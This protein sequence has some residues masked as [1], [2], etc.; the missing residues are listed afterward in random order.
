MN[1]KQ[2]G[3]IGHYTYKVNGM[4][5]TTMTILSARSMEMGKKYNRYI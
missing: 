1:K 4:A 2:M 5:Y 3:I